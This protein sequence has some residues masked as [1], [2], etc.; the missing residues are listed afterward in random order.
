V[1]IGPSAVTSTKTSGGGEVGRCAGEGEGGGA[2]TGAGGGIEAEG[3]RSFS[4]SQPPPPALLGP[5]AVRRFWVRLAVVAVQGDEALPRRPR[6]PLWAPPRAVRRLA[7]PSAASIPRVAAT[8]P[9]VPAAG[10]SVVSLGAVVSGLMA[11]VAAP[12]RAESRLRRARDRPR[13]LAPEVARPRKAGA[14][15]GVATTATISA[16]APLLMRLPSSLV[17]PPPPAFWESTLP[18]TSSSAT[19]SAATAAAVARSAATA[20]ARRARRAGASWR[21]RERV[22][23]GEGNRVPNTTMSSSSSLTWL[24]LALALLLLAVSSSPLESLSPRRRPR[25]V[26]RRPAPASS[27]TVC[28]RARFRPAACPLRAPRTPRLFVVVF[29][30]ST[31]AVVPSATAC[32]ASVSVACFASSAAPGSAAPDSAPPVLRVRRVVRVAPGGGCARAR[33][34]RPPR[35]P[36]AVRVVDGGDGEP[37]AAPGEPAPAWTTCRLAA[38]TSSPS[39]DGF[40][41]RSSGCVGASGCRSVPSDDSTSDGFLISPPFAPARC[42]AAGAVGSAEEAAAADAAISLSSSRRCWA[43]TQSPAAATLPIGT[44]DPLPPLPPPPAP[45][46]LLR[47]GRER[48]GRV[49]RPVLMAA[50][51]SIKGAVR[52]TAA[53][54][55]ATAAV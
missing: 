40:S 52:G 5:C 41:P 7:P 34:R 49:A 6:V 31:G 23:T 21:A 9:T 35:P 16:G 19:T 32:R 44:N 2:G 54:A 28:E 13:R 15:D 17:G 10:R 26:L 11:P 53:A 36:R 38:P 47:R 18:S 37:A 46:T 50:A 48:R 33:P 25:G 29:V 12:A 1:G 24:A 22:D 39:G 4:R 55:A 14:E 8:S 42:N 3:S 20:A 43:A 51:A 27:P 30:A 45:D